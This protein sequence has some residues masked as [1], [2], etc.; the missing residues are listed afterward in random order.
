MGA[1]WPVVGYILYITSTERGRGAFYD[2][3]RDR[4]VDIERSVIVGYIMNAILSALWA[5][6]SVFLFN[7]I[8]NGIMSAETYPREKHSCCCA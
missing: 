1:I 7:E 3:L 6:P 2:I 4:G 5:Y 8:R